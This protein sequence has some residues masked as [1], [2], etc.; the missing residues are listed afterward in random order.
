MDPKHSR[1]VCESVEL[2]IPP[3]IR[4]LSLSKYCEKYSTKNILV[5][6]LT[7]ILQKVDPTLIAPNKL[8][9]CNEGFLF[10]NNIPYIPQKVTKAS[11][12]TTM[13][14]LFHSF[15]Y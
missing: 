10:H 9:T 2:F 7:Q 3:S 11:Y 6:A 12:S 15:I 5:I 8:N 4:K 14:A 13:K 1:F